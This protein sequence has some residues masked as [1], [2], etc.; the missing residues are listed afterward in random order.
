MVYHSRQK[1]PKWFHS[2]QGIDLIFEN[3][4]LKNYLSSNNVK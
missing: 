4:D 1:R 3:N 2:E